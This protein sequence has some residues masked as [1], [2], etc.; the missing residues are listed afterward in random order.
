MTKRTAHL[1][2]GGLDLAAALACWWLL[3]EWQRID[4][5]LAS[6]E[7]VVH[8]QRPFGAVLVALVVPLIHAL[9]FARWAERAAVAASV[10]VLLCFG[11]LLMTA[12]AL[13]AAA[14]RTLIHAGYQ[15]CASMRGRMTFSRYEVWVNEA[16]RC[17]T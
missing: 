16:R 17:N 1:V 6:H 10:A 9:S 12:V 3:M 2:L 15:E 7:S 13:D 8:L 11:A 4:S 5:L 14:E